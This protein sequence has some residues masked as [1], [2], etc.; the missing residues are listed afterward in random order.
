MSDNIEVFAN[1]EA[2]F[3]SARVPAWHRLGTV[4]DGAM[5]AKEAGELAH[6]NGWN[7]RKTDLQTVGGLVIPR[8]VATIRTNPITGE[9]EALGVVGKDYKV[10][11]NE[12]AF[13]F[14]DALVDVGGA[15]FETAGG[16]GNGERVFMSMK[17][18]EGVMIA[19]EDAHDMYL[20]A[21]NS[22]DGSSAFH[23]AVTP[24]RVVCKNTLT[25]GLRAAKQKF[26]I[27]HT[28]NADGR[29]EEAREALKIAFKYA[30]EFEHQL[31]VLLDSAF[32]DAQFDALVKDLVPDSASEA[33]GWQAKVLERR[34]TLTHLFTTAETNTFGRGTKYAAY[35]AFTEYADWYMPVKGADLDGRKRAE[36][37]MAG[38]VVQQFK[39]KALA[40]LVR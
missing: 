10:I 27:R 36:R 30:D 13:A 2:A 12:E 23:V 26:S 35:N 7:V 4:T 24:V 14:L 17:L 6:L 29:I 33:E 11:Q 9:D 1:G 18:P 20:L 8:K 22:H 28:T 38:G 39:D 32:T 5:T 25:M 40:A 21:A 16:L 31:N 37:A 34:S 3:A 15:H 19:G